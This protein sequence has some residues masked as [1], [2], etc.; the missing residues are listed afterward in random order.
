MRALLDEAESLGIACVDL[1]AKEDGKPLYEKL[2][3]H[4]NKCTSMQI[5]L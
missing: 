2:G 1:L 5:K 3:F 4:V